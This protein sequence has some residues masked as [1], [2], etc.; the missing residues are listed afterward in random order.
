MKTSKIIR[1]A[2]RIVP[3][4]ILLQTL[5]FKFTAHPQ[6]VELFEKLN[7]EPYGRIGIGILELIAGVLLLIPKTTRFGALLSVGLMVGAIGSHLFILGIEV[8]GDGGF[9]FI[10]ALVVFITSLI[11]VLLNKNELINDYYTILKNNG[12]E[13]Q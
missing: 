4:V 10:L 11:N 2:L 5:F 7:A 9:L 8:M 3:A 1:W 13:L 12:H 6:S